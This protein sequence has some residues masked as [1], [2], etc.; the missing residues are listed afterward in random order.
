M[1]LL[2]PLAWGFVLIYVK[3]RVVFRACQPE[4]SNPTTPTLYAGTLVIIVRSFLSL[5]AMYT[6][7]TGVT[8]VALSNNN[9]C[10]LGFF[11]PD[12]TDQIPL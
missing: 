3:E 10:N 7:L 2:T 9:S 11:C 4:I 5:R 6:C 12:N 8:P 1:L